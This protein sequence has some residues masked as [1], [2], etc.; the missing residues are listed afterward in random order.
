MIWM[1][2][3]IVNCWKRNKRRNKSR[4]L[5]KKEV[6]TLS[7]VL[8][9]QLRFHRSWRK[10]KRPNHWVN[11]RW[12]QTTVAA[13]PYWLKGCGGC[14]GCCSF[15]RCLHHL[16]RHPRLST[17]SWKT[18]LFPIQTTR[19]TVSRWLAVVY[20]D[21]DRLELMLPNVCPCQIELTFQCLQDHLFSLFHYASL[22]RKVV[23]V[24]GCCCF[25]VGCCCCARHVFWKTLCCEVY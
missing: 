25:V 2:W 3:M 18:R 22:R 24:V 19:Q 21:V 23:V 14:G 7:V 1:I 8:S 17:I 6:A 5:W 10:R 13:T 15:S 12:K 4:M 9:R 20:V 11:R 16:F